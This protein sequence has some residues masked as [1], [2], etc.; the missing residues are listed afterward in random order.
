MRDDRGFTLLEIL[1]ALVVLG[2]LLAGLTQG[3][4]FGFHAWG[5]QSRDVAISETLATAE[6]VLRQ[7]IVQ[8]DPGGLAK[9]PDIVGGSSA[10]SFVTIL[11]MAAAG[12]GTRRADVWLGLNSGHDL[13]LRWTPHRHIIRF[14]P[15]P[16][17]TRSVLV[18]GLDHIEISYWD[19][20][21]GAW[22][23]NWRQQYLPAAVRIRLSF[24]QGDRHRWPDIVVATA[25]ERPAR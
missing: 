15:A 2:F 4:R 19:P 7:M 24:P 13:V 17:P 14:E 25:R 16:E 20:K 22:A 1:V 23:S 18:P 21:Q 6:R 9:P 11:P 8:M 5:A 3:I 12:W 10:I